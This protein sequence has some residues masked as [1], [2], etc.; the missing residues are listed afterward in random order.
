VKIAVCIKRVPDSETRIRIAA[1]G[2]SAD[3]AGVKF[4][5]NPYDEF[6]VEEALQR[7]E[8]AGAGEVVVIALGPDAA[9]ETMRTALAMG[10][11][12]GVLLRA[13]AI[14]ADALAVAKALAAELKDGGYDL[15]LFGKIAAD[16][17]AQAVGPMTAE[18]LG[19]P[20]VTAVSKLELDGGKGVAHREIEGGVEVVEFALP[21]VLTA[22]KGLN[23][24]R[25][26]ALK[27]IMA[28]KKKPV[29]VKPVTFAAP[30]LRVAA[31]EMPP[32]RKEGRIVGE[33]PDAVP[34][35]VR[36]LREE[37]KVL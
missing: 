8:K 14:P 17:Y 9:Q 25:Y 20:C 12:R 3:E 33:G 11:D 35:L 37:A 21:A 1:D 15:V 27:G 2:V 13:D 32:A 31:L 19:L 30:R 7:K 29:E 10:A 18:L 4:I 36:L 6:A 34:E 24:P 28:A 16:D 5:L 22:D 26:P 23:T